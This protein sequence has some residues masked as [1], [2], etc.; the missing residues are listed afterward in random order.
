M[1]PYELFWNYHKHD[2]LPYLKQDKRYES[3]EI[4][5][6]LADRKTL[7]LVLLMYKEKGATPRYL[8]QLMD[9]DVTDELALCDSLT[10]ANLSTPRY[11]PRAKDS[12]GP[13]STNT[14]QQGETILDTPT[15]GGVG[16]GTGNPE[17]LSTTP[18]TVTPLATG[19]PSPLRL[20][21]LAVKVKGDATPQTKQ[22]MGV[23]K[24]R[25]VLLCDTLFLGSFHRRRL[26]SLARLMN[27]VVDMDWV[28]AVASRVVGV[29]D[30]AGFVM[31]D[32]RLKYK[33]RHVHYRGGV[34]KFIELYQTMDDHSVTTFSLEDSGV[35]IHMSDFRAV[36]KKQLVR[37]TSSQ[38]N[39]G[40]LVGESL[41]LVILACSIGLPLRHLYTPHHFMSKWKSFR[42]FNVNRDNVVRTILRGVL[43][44]EKVVGN[45]TTQL[46]LRY[47]QQQ[48][49]FSFDIGNS[50][51][52]S[53]S[54]STYFYKQWY[55]Y[56]SKPELSTIVL[57]VDAL[58]HFCLT[59]A[60]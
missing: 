13:L 7:Q 29:N 19:L 33:D 18:P 24:E 6:S 12:T 50:T 38:H 41:S 10:Q 37:G 34:R 22:D 55:S 35:A 36:M 27:A 42:F 1:N 25:T 26:L 60:T 51:T 16:A 48:P 5:A 57:R 46:L 15:V 40:T 44:S 30:R 4:Q 32:D 17:Q 20:P 45:E 43:D 23:C 8:Q 11:A 21:P 28:R 54:V 58:K 49:F 2:Q 14:G 31:L 47:E 53:Q 39:S 56:P 52:T 9:I 59:P 3:H